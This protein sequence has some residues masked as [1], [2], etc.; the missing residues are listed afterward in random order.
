MRTGEFVI[1][2]S[3]AGRGIGTEA[4]RLILD[5]AFHIRNLRCVYLSVLSPNTAAIRAYEKAGFRKI[6]ERRQSGY[7]LGHPASETIMDAI[8]ADFPGPSI[9]RNMVESA[10]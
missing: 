5:Y 1:Q 3:P 9:V 8:P 10:L 6:G 4:T 2:L 7:W